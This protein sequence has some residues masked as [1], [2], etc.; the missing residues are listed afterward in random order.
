MEGRNLKRILSIE[1]KQNSSQVSLAPMPFQKNK[2]AG[3]RTPE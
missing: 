2:M 3:L 1:I